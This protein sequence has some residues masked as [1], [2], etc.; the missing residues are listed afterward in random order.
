MSNPTFSRVR[1]YQLGANGSN[2]SRVAEIPLPFNNAI[3]HSSSIQVRH[4]SGRI[5]SLERVIQPEVVNKIAARHPHYCSC[6]NINAVLKGVLSELFEVFEPVITTTLSK[7]L[8]YDTTLI[9]S[10]SKGKD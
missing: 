2:I 10:S 9:N 8:A 3:A 1:R 6:C 4:R 7:N 5:C